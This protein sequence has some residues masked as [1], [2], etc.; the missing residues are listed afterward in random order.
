MAQAYS[1][2]TGG[3]TNIRKDTRVYFVHGKYKKNKGRCVGIIWMCNPGN[4]LPVA[5]TVRWAPW[6]RLDPTMR[7][8]IQIL[9]EA[10]RIL[11]GQGLAAKKGDYVQVLNLFYVCNSYLVSARQQFSS[12]NYRECPVPS[13]KFTWLAWGQNNNPKLLPRPQILSGLRRPFFYDPNQKKVVPGVPRAPAYPVHPTARM[14]KRF[15]GYKDAVVQAIA[16]YLY[17]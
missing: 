15:Q 16:L 6:I 5:R 10:Q 12:S 14:Q 3:P 13:A 7:F 9:D 11:A 4:Q 8:V 2:W 1:E 17:L